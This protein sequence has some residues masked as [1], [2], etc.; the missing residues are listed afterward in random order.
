MFFMSY[1]VFEIW[2]AFYNY[3]IPRLGLGT[4]QVHDSSIL[5]VPTV[6][7]SPDTDIKNNIQMCGC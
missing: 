2:C 3:S 1:K 6:L 5:L 4:F 7:G